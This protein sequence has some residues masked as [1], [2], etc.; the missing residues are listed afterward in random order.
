MSFSWLPVPE[1]YIGNKLRWVV[2]VTALIEM[3]WCGMYFG[4]APIQFVMKNE[5][6]F[7]QD[8]LTK[9]NRT[10]DSLNLLQTSNSSNSLD[11][12]SRD[13][14]SA[15]TPSGSTDPCVME[16]DRIFNWLYLTAD[17]TNYLTTYFFGVIFDLYGSRAMRLACNVFLFSGSI[18]G[19]LARPGA[20]EWLYY[21]MMFCLGLGSIPLFISNLQIGNL[22]INSELVLS[23]INGIFDAGDGLTIVPK[24]LSE[25]YGTKIYVW[26][27]VF[28][29]ATVFFFFRTMLLMPVSFFDK[30]SEKKA[31]QKAKKESEVILLKDVSDQNQNEIS[32]NSDSK[33][34]PVVKPSVSNR[35]ILQYVMTAKFIAFVPWFLIMDLRE[36]FFLQSVNPWLNWQGDNDAKFTSQYTDLFSI[37]QLLALPCA[38]F[39]GGVISFG[40]WYYKKYHNLD[41]TKPSEMI[42]IKRYC[43]SWLF[44]TI[45]LLTTVWSWMASFKL[46]SAWWN[47]VIFFLCIFTRTNMYTIW[48]IWTLTEFPDNAFG[49]LSGVIVFILG[50]FSA[51]QQVMLRIAQKQGWKEVQIWFAVAVMLVGLWKFWYY[52]RYAMRMHKRQ[53]EKEG[54]TQN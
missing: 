33:D 4:W 35:K 11:S 21:P 41:P 9:N 27:S 7:I 52:R 38:T 32:E 5:N 42:S 6:Y 54:E 22:F 2:F 15:S 3:P 43:L 20:T 24:Y 17:I 8:C 10:L 13:T 51:S 14:R 36:K 18:F 19:M 29:A 48:N 37:M 16:Q 46:K 49:R 30:K 26:W 34:E 50:I 47:N 25:N 28:C 39:S 31:L 44:L 45:A 1:K 12:I 40:T 23:M 53:F